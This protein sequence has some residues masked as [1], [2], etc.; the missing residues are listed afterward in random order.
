MQVQAADK[1]HGGGNAKSYQAA[2]D[3]GLHFRKSGD[4]E[5][6]SFHIFQM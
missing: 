5:S 1:T 2:V 4:A 3:D 6:L